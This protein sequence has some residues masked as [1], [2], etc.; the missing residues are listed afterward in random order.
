MA[1]NRTA[2]GLILEDGVP[3]PWVGQTMSLDEFLR[4]PEVKPHLEFTDGMVT[5]KMPPKPTHG[6]VQGLFWMRFNQIAGSAPPRCGVP[7]DALRYA[8]LGA[9]AQVSSTTGASVSTGTA[10]ARQPT[11]LRS[12][13]SPWRS[14]RQPRA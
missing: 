1:A 3:P 9:G 5:Q 10:I 14:C 7:R 11:S 6:A 12:Q 2:P 13:I 8:D 4:L